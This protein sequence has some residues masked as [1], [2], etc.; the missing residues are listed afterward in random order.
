MADL[1]DLGSQALELME[2]TFGWTTGCAWTDALVA[3]TPLGINTIKRPEIAAADFAVSTAF[4]AL[5]VVWLLA[6]G[7]MV[8]TTSKPSDQVVKRSHIEAAFATNAF[9]FFVG[10][11]CSLGAH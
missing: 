3:H 5:G 6:S 10:W 9:I 4:T 2:S 11:S 7:Q 8:G 1:C